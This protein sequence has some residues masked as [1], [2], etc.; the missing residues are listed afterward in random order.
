[1]GKR[2]KGKPVTKA[3]D[4]SELESFLADYKVYPALTARLDAFHGDYDAKTINEIVLWKLSRYVELPDS[5]L[6]LLNTVRS[7]LLGQHEQAREL[8]TDLQN[9]VG[10]QIAM[11]STFLR[12]ANPEVFQ[13]MDGH[14]YRAVYGTTLEDRLKIEKTAGARTK[15]YL[16]YLE[17]LRDLCEKKGIRFNDADR[18]LFEFDKQ[19]N[20]PLKPRRELK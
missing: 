20:P 7:L 14:A 15:L 3:L 19:T 6:R 9:V 8:I 4:A 12:F 16:K 13:I 11:A 5:L 2:N 10:V 1:M 18:I 17:D